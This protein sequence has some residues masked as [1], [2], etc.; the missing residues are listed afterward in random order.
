[1]SKH[2]GSPFP[3]R[4][5]DHL[6]QAMSDSKVARIWAD[7][8]D[9]ARMCI[10]IQARIAAGATVPEAC[11]AVGADVGRYMA[12]VTRHPSAKEHHDRAMRTRAALVEDAMYKAAVGGSVDTVEQYDADGVLVG[13]QVRR[14][15]CDVKAA[16]AVLKA[17]MREQYGDKIEHT[18]EIKYEPL[19]IS[20]MPTNVEKTDDNVKSAQKGSLT[21]NL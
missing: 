9:R 2:S 11:T 6:V 21:V 19:A 3:T 5:H 10:A 1:M 8:S 18:G 14:Q 20:V 15:G 17:R 4:S 12:M 7:R 13:R 16:Q